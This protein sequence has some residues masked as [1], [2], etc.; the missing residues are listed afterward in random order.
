MI[1]DWLKFKKY[2]HIGIPLT[3]K[4]DLG[5]IIDYVTNSQKIK[6]HKFTPLLHKKINQRKFRPTSN[7]PKT[8]K[9]KRL[10]SVQNRKERPIFYASHLDSIIYSYYSH[11]LTEAYESYLTNKEFG[12][13]AVAYRKIPIVKEKNG[14]K[15]NVEF[16][17]DTFKF[18]E[19]NKERKLTAIVADITSFFDNLDHRILH[20]QW[21]QVLKIRDLP[22][23]H[24]NIY[25]SLITKKYVNEVELFHRFKDN[26]I[27]ER[28]LMSDPSKIKLK[29]IKVK[30]IWN[31][32]KERVVSY[33]N[34]EEFFSKAIDLIR[35]EKQ[36]SFQ[37]KICRQNCVAKGIPQGTP[38]SATLANIYMLDFDDIIHNETQKRNAYYQR[39]SDDLIIVCQQDDE[40]FFYKLIT[41]TIE[42]LAKLDIQR[43]KTNI[44]R[45][46]YSEDLKAFDGGILKD[47]VISRNKQLEYLGF[48]YD[49]NKVKV[50]TVGLSK[51]YR[52]MK[53][54]FRRGIHFASKPENKSHNLFEERLYKR[55]SY[56]GAKRRLIYKRDTKSETGFK[57]TKEQYWGNYISYLEKANSVM[58]PINGDDSIKSQYSKF[59][60]NFGK[61]MKKAYAEIGQKVLKGK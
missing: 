35:V 37:H 27:A 2:P 15:S 23:D 54:A 18:I 38:I 33:C 56:K 32:K 45:Y 44:Y 50:K 59:W 11:L 42:K 52:S 14:N 20:K 19:E 61:E 3:K 17:F 28:G 13:C 55:F 40:D 31:L 7:A 43:K 60:K 12:T 26:L 6:K 57:K 22:D 41:E 16:A 36:C 4:N 51:F 24:Y 53:R 49:G 30:K 47:G 21:K 8:P 1:P 5:W 29:N 34:K 9:G 25:K 39:Y 10:R 48:V 58:K 46:S